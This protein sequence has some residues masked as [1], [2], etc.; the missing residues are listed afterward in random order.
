[1]LGKGKQR[2]V[3]KDNSS[4]RYDLSFVTDD[5]HVCYV[6]PGFARMDHGGRNPITYSRHRQ[7]RQ[8]EQR[9]PLMWRS[10]TS[11]RPF[12]GKYSQTESGLIRR[13]NTGFTTASG[14][15]WRSNLPGRNMTEEI[16]GEGLIPT[17]EARGRAGVDGLTKYHL[18]IGRVNHLMNRVDGVIGDLEK[19]NARRRCTECGRFVGGPRKRLRLD[20]DAVLKIDGSAKV[21]GDAGQV[22]GEAPVEESDLQLTASLEGGDDEST[23]DC[24]PEDRVMPKKLIREVIRGDDEPLRANVTSGTLKLRK[25]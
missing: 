4:A 5:L 6:H 24:S 14:R 18:L 21:A 13:A 23:L 15:P 3:A 22:L 20:D 10:Q 11:R 9:R 8:E 17:G 19:A 1:M 12:Y 16:M 25:E 7:H 2:P